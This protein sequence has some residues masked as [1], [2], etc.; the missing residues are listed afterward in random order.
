MLTLRVDADGVPLEPGTHAEIQDLVNEAYQNLKPGQ[1]DNLST[2]LGSYAERRQSIPVHARYVDFFPISQISKF[3]LKKATDDQLFELLQFT[4]VGD[5]VEIVIHD[6]TLQPTK[7]GNILQ[8]GR[9]RSADIPYWK[10]LREHLI[11]KF[12]EANELLYSE[13]EL[14]AGR[15][16]IDQLARLI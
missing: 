11:L 10:K 16:M 13:T 15:Q 12:S 14:L 5:L 9:Y 3:Y 8:Q 6:E 7:L 2:Q 1:L 4:T